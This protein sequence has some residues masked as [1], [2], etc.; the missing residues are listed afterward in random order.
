LID[1]CRQRADFDVLGRGR[2]IGGRVLWARVVLDEDLEHPRVAFAIGRNKG[3]AVDRNRL[4][5]RIQA[6][7]RSRADSLPKGTYM[8]GSRSR[9][10]DV[11]FDEVVEDIE[12]V[13]AEVV[14][15]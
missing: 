2:R 1:R 11:T 3:C 8:F 7:L 5:R 15:R 12:Y 4:R 6:V 14:R 10:R 13:L 9:A